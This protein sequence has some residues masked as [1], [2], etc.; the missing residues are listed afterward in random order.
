MLPN[1]TAAKLWLDR[2]YMKKKCG[3]QVDHRLL[4]PHELNHRQ[5]QRG[6]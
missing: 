2:N 4:V 6:K 3:L 5:V 1:K